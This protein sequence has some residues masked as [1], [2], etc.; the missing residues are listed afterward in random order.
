V[1][2]ELR[3]TTRLAF[4]PNRVHCIIEIPLSPDNVIMDGWRQA[5]DPGSSMS[6]GIRTRRPP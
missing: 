6:D 4:E 5:N 3:G 1:P 2:Y